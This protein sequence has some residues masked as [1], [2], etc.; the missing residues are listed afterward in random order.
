MADTETI[1]E[2]LR[3]IAALAER[4]VGGE[5]DNAK[6]QLDRLLAKHGLMM[7]DLY[8][9]QDVEYREFVCANQ[10][11]RTILTQ[12][13][14]KAM[15]ISHVVYYKVRR[16]PNR[17]GIKC[18]RIDF[19]EIE[20]M[21]KH[22][23]KLLREEEKRLVDAFICRHELYGPSDGESNTEPLSYEEYI[24][25]ISLAKGMRKSNYVSTRRTLGAGR[26]EKL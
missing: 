11:E 3:K 1:R 17:I 7:E 14:A 4:G 8:P 25:L 26:K 13:V 18:G 19:I 20:H 2:K 23:R 6:R 10:R 5:R 21:Y 22:F 16:N 12:C 15:G 24:A 9:K